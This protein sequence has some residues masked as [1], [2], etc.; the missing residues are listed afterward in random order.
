MHSRSR[1]SQRRALIRLL[2]ISPLTVVGV[3]AVWSYLNTPQISAHNFDSEIWQRGSVAERGEMVWT[4]VES[5]LLLDKTRSEVLNMLGE[6]DLGDS[7]DSPLRYDIDIGSG[8]VRL[9][10][11]YLLAV[12]FDTSSGIVTEVAVVQP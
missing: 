4:L 8:K 9:S 3:I 2:V 7:T 10:W 11:A 5:H 1:R 12:S 6:P